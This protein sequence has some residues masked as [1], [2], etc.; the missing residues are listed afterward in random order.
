MVS[1]L[2]VQADTVTITAMTQ[3]SRA[4]QRPIDES[5]AL[6]A[7]DARSMAFAK[8]RLKCSEFDSAEEPNSSGSAG[9]TCHC[10]NGGTL[11]LL[12]TADAGGDTSACHTVCYT[13]P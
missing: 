7:K 5:M 8:N 10:G 4:R 9:M 3:Q 13:I 1:L 2:M 11:Q 6:L 12:L